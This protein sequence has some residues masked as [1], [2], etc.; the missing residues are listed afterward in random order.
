MNFNEVKEEKQEEN[1]NTTRKKVCTS[2]SST[3]TRNVAIEHMKFDMEDNGFQYLP[4]RRV[5]MS[6]DYLHYRRQ[7]RDGNLIYVA[8]AD[9]YILL[10]AC[11]KLSE[12]DIRILHSGV[13]KFEKRLNWIEQ[14]IDQSLNL[15]HKCSVQD[16]A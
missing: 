2:P 4:P 7:K 11:A 10:R 3:I 1:Q 8:H 12:V 14:R 5:K 15:L 13:L 9:Y 6:N 16:G